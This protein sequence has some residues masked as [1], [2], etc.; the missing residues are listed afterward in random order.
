MENQLAQANPKIPGTGTWMRYEAYKHTTTIES[1]KM[2]GCTTGDLPYA[3]KR[4]HLLLHDP[5]RGRRH[6]ASDDGN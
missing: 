1:A 2:C 3:W 6:A 5:A 4:G